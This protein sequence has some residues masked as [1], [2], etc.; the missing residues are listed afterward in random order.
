MASS[1]AALHEW[2]KFDK[3][4]QEKLL[5]N[6]FFINCHITTIIDYEIDTDKF[7]LILKGKC[8]KCGRNVTRVIENDL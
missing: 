6:V 2:S 8:K 7:G 1:K 5:A 4:T 3:E